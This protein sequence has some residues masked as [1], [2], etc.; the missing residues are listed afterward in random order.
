ML[1]E[2]EFESL[3]DM[4]G[5]PTEGRVILS[6]IRAGDPERRV[7]SSRVAGNVSG[8]FPSRKMGRTIQFESHSVELRAILVKYEYD[9][10]C[11]EYWDQPF[12]IG[13]LVYEGKNEKKVRS[14]HTPD[15]LVVTRHGI[16]VDEWKP[17]HKLLALEE[18][19]GSRFRR[20]GEGTWRFPSAERWCEERGFAYRVRLDKELDRFL[21]QNVDYLRDY[22]NPKAAPPTPDALHRIE[23]LVRP[24]P[25]ISLK[26][27]LGKGVS[28]DDLL[29]LI[30]RGDLIADLE[31]QLLH[32][33]ENAYVYRTSDD[34][35]A[36]RRC[37]EDDFA[38]IPRL[39][40]A[41]RLEEGTAILWDGKPWIVAN[42]G[43]SSVFL[44]S[45]SDTSSSLENEHFH[46]LLAYGEIVAP[47]AM[48]GS[49]GA[50]LIPE[51]LQR[52]PEAYKEALR[53]MEILKKLEQNEP[54][55][56]DEARSVRTYRRWRAKAKESKIGLG[57]EL[58]GLLPDVSFRG[59]RGSKVGS[60]HEALAAKA[61]EAIETPDRK[62]YQ[63][64]YQSYAVA[65]EEK[66]E[67][68]MSE[69]SFLKR[70]REKPLQK[71][72]E[73]REGHK[74]AYQVGGFVP[75]F[76]R[77]PFRHGVHPWDFAHI[78]HTQV[79]LFLGSSVGL[80][81]KE[82]PWLTLIIATQC[83]RVL[84]FYLT[85]EPPSYV[86]CMM[87]LREVIRRFGRLPKTILVDGGKD[88]RSTDFEV[89]LARCESGR[90]TRPPHQPRFGSM[91][92]SALGLT[93]E[94][95]FNN[96]EGNSQATRERTMTEATDPRNRVRFT[97]S[98]LHAVLRKFF[99][100]IYDQS[101]HSGIGYSPRESYENGL[102]MGGAREHVSIPWSQE[103]LY[104][105]S[106]SV[107]GGTRKVIYRKGIEVFGIDYYSYELD[108]NGVPDTKIEVKY[109]PD[110][111]GH[112]F[113]FANNRWVRCL[114]EHHQVFER[115]TVK[116]VAIASASLRESERT[117]RSSRGER[118][119]NLVRYLQSGEFI[120]EIKNRRE[121]AVETALSTPELR[122]TKGI[123]SERKSEIKTSSEPEKKGTQPT[124]PTTSFKRVVYGRFRTE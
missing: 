55:D 37:R 99:Y 114:S 66:G 116:E 30:A 95:L 108:A 103:I 5:I 9:S 64:A 21:V 68:P 121:K 105:S 93:I 38:R 17:E 97:L 122:M 60:E 86:S 13:S 75:A 89:F 41:V 107:P 76:E 87:A 26:A 10:D 51:Y 120:E 117:K 24:N 70:L 3:V 14:K 53:R 31:N 71:F 18:K 82:K 111:A 23:E 118:M 57:W 106:P 27:L 15:F 65:C 72:V 109:D 102:K 42:L 63:F 44:K 32:D 25:W 124:N 4:L 6:S 73:S 81:W 110:N 48:S 7:A 80:E 39:S 69:K 94:Q 79:P 43:Q 91:I 123:A 47:R 85:F 58:V 49:K 52:P 98:E 35:E 16:F 29:Y 19:G 115:W 56:I 40:G 22:L 78:D 11:L 119:K 36:H 1:T 45:D 62:S 96:L 28:S 90:K 74:V 104:L 83:R 67:T 101:P 33:I 59:N 88:F 113:A 84:G 54:L 8:T 46:R 77:D 12:T 20:E 61:I 92:E 50:D 2:E 100:E 34:R 112:V